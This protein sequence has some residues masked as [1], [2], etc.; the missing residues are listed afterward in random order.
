MSM[1]TRMRR[2]PSFKN[3]AFAMQLSASRFDIDEP[4]ASNAAFDRTSRPYRTLG[5]KSW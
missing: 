3:R 5:H 4:F 2:H 1:S